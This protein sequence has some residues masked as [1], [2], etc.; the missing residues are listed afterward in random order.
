MSMQLEELSPA[1]LTTYIPALRRYALVLAG[2]R[3]LADDLVQETLSRAIEHLDRF[4]PGSNL[5][6]WLR[7]ILRNFY[8]NAYARRAGRIRSWRSDEEEIASGP[9]TEASQPHSVALTELWQALC[10]L[11][12]EQREVILLVGV[13]ELSYEEA[14]AVLQV[15]IGTIRSRLSRARGKL[16]HLSGE[17]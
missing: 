9:S 16:L 7:T 15:P 4:T 3:D 6:A 5:R 12:L 10:A 17:R 2:D 1:A 13:E 11:P 8:F 14:A